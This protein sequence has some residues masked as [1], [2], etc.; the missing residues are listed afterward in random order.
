LD[1]KNLLPE[2][3]Q[4]VNDN[5]GLAEP[6][7]PVI[8]ALCGSQD[9]H[10]TTKAGKA[11]RGDPGTHVKTG[12][13]SSR[14]PA[15]LAQDA[16]GQGMP[17][18]VQN[19]VGLAPPIQVAVVSIP[20]IVLMPPLASGTSV[21]AAGP[22]REIGVPKG[23]D[24]RR[25]APAGQRVGEP[26]SPGHPALAAPL[27]A[28]S[29]GDA[30]AGKNPIKF[31][32]APEPATA[33]IRSDV[34]QTTLS[35]T[36]PS[37][38]LH[39]GQ[40]QPALPVDR[41]APTDQIVPALVSTLKTADGTASV[42]VRLQPPELGQVRIRI[43]QTTVGPAHINI[44]TERPETLQL[45]QRDEPRLQ[46]ALDQAGVSSAGRTITF[47]VVTQEQTVATASRP[48]SMTSDSSDSGQGQSGGTWRQNEDSQ[49]NFSD[50]SAPDQG[51]ARARWFRAGLDITA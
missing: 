47:Q 48:D 36:G 28:L 39:S 38:P 12:K 26:S 25:P 32:P 17:G 16:V 11:P 20:A 19:A 37:S 30:E 6:P 40:D 13:E 24:V 9:Q 44:T 5:A 41:A 15:P 43:D 22:V 8:V 4:P 18:I 2:Q 45:L 46:Q 50:G 34:P 51:Q 14:K 42:T 33:S 31:E 3:I 21:D 35:G 29:M 27:A 23:A 1:N 7:V 10:E 49:S